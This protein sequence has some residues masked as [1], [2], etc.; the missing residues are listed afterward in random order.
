[1]K[2]LLIIFICFIS[3]CGMSSCGKVNSYDDMK[4]VIYDAILSKSKD[5]Y[6]VYVYSSTCS[7]CEDIEKDL[8]T[9][10]N[11]TKEHSKAPKI[12]VLNTSLKKINGAILATSDD[13][14]ENFVGTADFKDVKISNA[15]ALFIIE[16]NTVKK[17]IS[18]KVTSKP[19][20][21]ILEYLK[22]LMEK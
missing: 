1:M 9:Y 8:V 21:D 17:I 10:A 18:T 20:T 5:K 13:E 6:L 7:V 3:L 16:N 2:K 22:S 19:K 14:Y 11:Y 15:P 4:S 12:F